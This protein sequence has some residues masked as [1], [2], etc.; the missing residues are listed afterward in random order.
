[1][2]TQLYDSKKLKFFSVFMSINLLAEIFFPNIAFALTSGPSQ[3]EV[4]SFE[5]VSTSE[6]V[7]LF[8]GDFN[9][10]IPLL[11]V[12]NYPINLAYHSGISMDQEASWVG[13]GWNINPGAITR[14]LRGLPDDL[15]GEKVSKTFFIKDN[16]THG[17]RVGIG[18]ELFGLSQFG[19]SGSVSVGA[20]HNNY[21]GRGFEFGVSSSLSGLDLGKL[22]G[23]ASLGL[24][25]NTQQG[26]DIR[27][28]VGFYA[29]IDSK[30]RMYGIGL[31]SNLGLS[32]NSR[33]GVARLNVGS[34]LNFR[35]SKND[36][37][38][39]KGGSVGFNL[40]S[41]VPLN[42][43]MSYTPELKASFTNTSRSF[44]GSLGGEVYGLYTNGFFNGYK[45]VQKVKNTTISASGYGYMYSEDGNS[46]NAL[47]DFNREKDAPYTKSTPSLPLTNFTYDTY[48]VTGQGIAGNFRPYRSDV[49]TVYDPSV[50]S[51]TN[52]VS[53]AGELGFGAY[54]KGG[55]NKTTSSARAKSGKWEVNNS[56][57]FKQASA[58]N[59]KESFYFKQAGEKTMVNQEYF[60]SF[61]DESPVK[62]DINNTNNFKHGS[63]SNPIPQN[64][65]RSREKRSQNISYLTASEASNFALE[66]NLGHDLEGNVIGRTDNGRKGHHLSEVTVQKPNGERYVYG[67]PAY[68]TLQ[69]EI[70]FAINNDDQNFG[71]SGLAN[72]SGSSDN[73][74]V[75]ANTYDEYYSKTELPAYAHSYLLTAVL[76]PDYIDR[77]LDGITPDDYG[78][79]T[80]LNY[81]RVDDNYKWRVPF[82]SQ[83][84]MHNEGFKSLNEDKANV[85][86]GEKE[87]WHL[88]SIETKNYEA[89]FTISERD[90]AKGTIDVDGGRDDNASSYKLDKIEL[91]SKDLDDSQSE[92]LKTVH[93]TYNYDLCKGVP[94]QLYSGQGKLTLE[95]VYFTYGN[96]PKSKLNAYE[97][98]YNN[99]IIANYDA[100]GYDRWGNYKPNNSPS[101]EPSNAE[102]PYTVQDYDIAKQRASVWSLERISLPSGGVIEVDLE[103]DDYAFVQ[104]K[105]AMQMVKVA[106]SGDNSLNLQ[107][108]D[109]I[110]PD[111]VTTQEQLDAMCSGINNNLYFRFLVDLTGKQ[112]YEYVSAFA[113]LQSWTLNNNSGTPT[114]HIQLSPAGIK[115]DN[116]G[117]ACSPISK[118]AWNYTRINTPSLLY[119]G[120]NTNLTNDDPISVLKGL[121]LFITEMT[122]L[123]KGANKTLLNKGYGLKYK[124]A[125]SWIR[126]NTPN[127]HKFGGGVRV[128]SLSISDSWDEMAG[129]DLQKYVQ[130]YDYEL[131]DGISS[132]V[133]SYEP[134]VGKDENP[135]YLP[136]AHTEDR[137]L[138][139]DKQHYITKPYGEAF[140]PAPSV[141]YSKVTVKNGFHA[142]INRHGT[143]KV[144]HEFYTA[145]DFPV[146]VRKTDVTSKTVGPSSWLIKL[147]KTNI[148]E[149]LTTSQGYSIINNDMHGKPKSQ[150]V[151]AQG[152][153][154]EIS[155][156]TYLYKTKNINELDNEVTVLTPKGEKLTAQIGVEMD[157]INDM[158]EQ[159]NNSK[160]ISKQKNIDVVPLIFFPLVP[161]PLSNLF[162]SRKSEKT[163]YRTTV[164]T[165]V[166]SKY[167]V[168]EEVRAMEN[169]SVVSTKNVAFDSETG[170]VL[171]TQ[172][173]NEFSDP[174]YDLN[175]PA[176]WAYDG[177]EG[178]YQ[179]TGVVVDDLAT[180]TSNSEHKLV[181]NCSR[182]FKDGDEVIAS[183]GGS[184]LRLWVSQVVDYLGNSNNDYVVFI[185]ENGTK[186]N[187]NISSVK[188][189]RS[190]HRN[191]QTNSIGNVKLKESPLGTY[192][193][194]TSNPFNLIT[195]TFQKVIDASAIE[196]SEDWSVKCSISDGVFK[197]YEIIFNPY[198]KSF[199][200][201]WRFKGN[202]F[203]KGDR[204]ASQNYLREAGRYISYSPFWQHNNDSEI[205]NFVMSESD[206]WSSLSE[207]TIYSTYG[208][209]V[210][211]KD[212]LGRY[213]AALFG[214]NHSLVEAV[215]SNAKHREIAVNNFEDYHS[216]T[217]HFEL[218]ASDTSNISDLD[219][220]TGKYSLRLDDFEESSIYTQGVYN[221]IVNFSP[222]S[223][224]YV[225]SAWVKT[226]PLFN[227]TTEEGSIIISFDENTS[228]QYVFSP[229]GEKIEGWRRVYGEFEVP[230]G[231]VLTFMKTTFKAGNNYTYFDD[232]RIHPYDASMKTYVYHPESK[233]LDAELDENNYATFYEYD[234]EGLLVRV[235]KE[236]ERGIMTIQEN[237]QHLSQ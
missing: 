7:D 46:K 174:L 68:N 116:S 56:L 5:P 166:V 27:S 123:I 87:I 69:K 72:Y 165:K 60:N 178:A 187:D 208:N 156:I 91:F 173:T 113:K 191:M 106:G 168:L 92:L 12:G 35:S 230:S 124:P 206:N 192:F 228:T 114:A 157:V 154:V 135:F 95:S 149:H 102:F 185:D 226:T 183:V 38:R 159:T 31:G 189:I 153:D 112:D 210:E 57:K 164:L 197:K 194:F 59:T 77:T 128:K 221:C 222:E 203:Y 150:K 16:I 179:N 211:N 199:L 140:F 141:G 81:V 30:N 169:G 11:N 82:N 132:G 108:F 205:S 37:G 171:L 55:H 122:S 80:K 227:A 181:N 94:N 202:Y 99:D 193:S 23:T 126:L 70:T 74:D 225:L 47:H 163:S 45:S 186:I 40:G 231:S 144:E 32:F 41:S 138:G 176:H 18:L 89:I 19:V 26:I 235:K 139:A 125:F 83:K 188:V 22:S 190:G 62:I 84:A 96:S 93:F 172:T 143:G 58:N 85:I 98:E 49:G 43:E 50:S 9:Y 129:G 101:N 151:F 75:A 136:D 236:T 198:L 44:Q 34:S 130:T 218:G 147:F 25:F 180:S 214:Y 115:D 160:V 109:I 177:M 105:K 182:F 213:S 52:G 184:N 79:A 24:N 61:Y 29:S 1:M 216:N 66:N 158:R 103:S 78:T 229:S 201:S 134:A 3:P 88:A 4:Q 107:G 155:S 220:H 20:F 131:Q 219:A 86:Y 121:G 152:Q 212:I 17:C 137:K 209:E 10:N 148:E 64:T 133:A 53:Q 145:K 21:K 142:D 207:V 97:F 110:L 67:I 232:V 8:S 215:A 233:R 111:G 28:S 2:F 104:N 196:Y 127:G 167:G 146:K 36:N 48:T 73:L 65:Q 234:E 170:E 100:K 51:N 195:P 42:P 15:K 223:G 33:Q 76:S 118:A 120:S 71:N 237:R 54:L 217:T 117:Q 119:P 162:T 6:M 224:K 13:L 204:Y 90:D 175:Y 63:S 39:I 161:F 14:G 200:G